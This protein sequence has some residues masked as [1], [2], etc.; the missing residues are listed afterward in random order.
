MS[1]SAM[2]RSNGIDM[3]SRLEAA[4]LADQI[5]RGRLVI[6]WVPHDE[7]D[8]RAYNELMSRGR[9]EV[10][11]IPNNP[12]LPPITFGPNPRQ[13]PHNN[14][15]HSYRSAPYNLQNRS[16]TSTQTRNPTFCVNGSQSI[17]PPPCEP[18]NHPQ[19]PFNPTIS[20]PTLNPTMNNG[21]IPQPNNHQ[22]N[23]IPLPNNRQTNSI[24]LPNRS[25]NSTQQPNRSTSNPPHS[26]LTPP[27]H[28]PSPSPPPCFQT[29]A[30]SRNPSTQPRPQPH[31]FQPWNNGD[32][33]LMWVP[34]D[35]TFPP[36][37]FL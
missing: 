31:Q 9:M 4:Y 23:S 24:P 2:I 20:R 3:N 22:T 26:F 7:G 11:F 21:N 28:P 10:Q 5:S 13:A 16:L 33:R 34:D 8:Q 35:P 17:N 14:N 29:S 30:N 18:I 25:N 32:F 12:H 19:Q 6:M 15:L 1:F 37:T 36:Q 27:P